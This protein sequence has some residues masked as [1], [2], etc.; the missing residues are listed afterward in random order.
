MTTKSDLQAYCTTLEANSL[1]LLNYENHPAG[2]TAQYEGY[3]A[4][5]IA[6]LVLLRA[7]VTAL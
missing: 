5:L 1:N 3:V 7:Y 6:N 4:T 2:A